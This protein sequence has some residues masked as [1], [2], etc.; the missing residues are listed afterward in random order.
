[1]SDYD[2]PL[3][4]VPI[5]NANDEHSKFFQEQVDQAVTELSRSSLV[6]AI[7][8][9][10]GDKIF[11]EKIKEMESA[12]KTLLVVSGSDFS[13]N[14]TDYPGYSAITSIWKGKI[15]FFKGEKFTGF[16]DCIGPTKPAA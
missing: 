11:A 9:N 1:M 6:V 5:H 15:Y 8:Y 16:T 12:D 4:M 7:G 2:F 13:S 10:F 14:P 3:M